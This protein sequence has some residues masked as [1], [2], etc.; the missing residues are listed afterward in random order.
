MA[1]LL[2]CT[3]IVETQYDS[4]DNY[5]PRSVE[6][7]SKSYN[8]E[9]RSAASKFK[10]PQQDPYSESAEHDSQT[11]NSESRLAPSR[12]PKDLQDN[13]Y[14]GSYYSRS[15]EHDLQSYRESGK[16][17]LDSQAYYE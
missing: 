12:Q 10:D 17:Q 1:N 2:S 6:H 7:D 13:Y 8:S 9:S 4:Q 11:Y 3:I 15:I 14:S 5:Y 16:G